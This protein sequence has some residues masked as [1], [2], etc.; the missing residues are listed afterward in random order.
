MIEKNTI[1][2]IGKGIAL[3]GFLFTVGT[4][5]YNQYVKRSEARFAAAI[6][7]VDAYSDDG[8]RTLEN[9]LSTRLLYYNDGDTNLNN[10]ADYD[11]EDFDFAAKETLFGYDG[12]LSAPDSGLEPYLDEMQDITDF[13]AQVSFCIDASI[14]DADVLTRYI[15]PRAE[16]FAM[17]NERLMAW[18]ANYSNIK[19]W[20]R[21]LTSLLET[22]R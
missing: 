17:Q 6:E 13:Y 12:E 15:C 4:F 1:D 21:G 3:A 22:C 7:L 10:P 2:L 11:D 14:C 5:S 16:S 18:Y 20:N 8:I 9:R 19:D